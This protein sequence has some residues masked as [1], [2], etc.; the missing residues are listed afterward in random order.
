MENVKRFALFA[1]ASYYPCGGW[2]DLMGYF[3]TAEDAL[4]ADR[5]YKDWWHVV[6]LTSG[7]IVFS[8]N[9]NH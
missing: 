1:G 6:D 9:T 8:G 5:S 2:R 7:E 3:D 4:C